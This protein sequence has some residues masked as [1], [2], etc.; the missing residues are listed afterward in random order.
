MAIFLQLDAV[1]LSYPEQ[2][3]VVRDVSLHVNKGEIHCLIGR[4]GCGKTSLLKVAAGLLRPQQG[5]VHLNGIALQ[6]P[7]TE[8]GF[9]FQAPTLLDWLGV[10]DNLLLPVGLHRTVTVADRRHAAQL[11]EQLGLTNIAHSKVSGLSGGQQSRVA[12]ARALILKPSMLFMDEPFAALDAITRDELQRDFL[13]LCLAF[14]TSV[15]FVT[16]DISEAVYLGHRVSCMRA[17]EINASYDV[18]LPTPR[19]PTLRYSPPFNALC[20]RLRAT[21]DGAQC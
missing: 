18:N 14:G 16:H 9:V 17:G 6:A 15:L 5:A 13:K 12:I 1:S 19:Q 8:M 2:S 11:L 20:E 3:H 10:S 21:M 4:S 7:R